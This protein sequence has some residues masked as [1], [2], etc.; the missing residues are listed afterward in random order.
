MLR[1]FL[2][3]DFHGSDVVFRKFVNALD[4]YKCDI[5]FFAGD[6]TG[7]AMILVKD[8]GNSK[9]ETEFLGD[10]VFLRSKE[11]LDSF[12]NKV[13]SSGFYYKII[14]NNE[15]IEDKNLEL[16]MR[17][18]M[19]KR[20]ETW[21]QIIHNK[22]KGSNKKFYFIT[23]ND[24]PSEIK[25]VIKSY[26]DDN[27]VDAN[28]KTF[29]LPNGMEGFGLPYSNITPWKLPG[30]LTEDALKDKIEFLT[31]KLKDPGNSVFLIHV[32]PKDTVIDLAPVLEN[33]S[34]KIDMSGVQMAHVGSTAVRDAIL[35][36][37]PVASLHGHIHESRGVAKIGRTYA[38]NAGSEYQQGILRGVILNFDERPYKL[39]SYLFVYG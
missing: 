1:A 12:L 31:S 23:G 10:K 20:T 2:A 4:V 34:L 9:Y 17:E 39:K 25:D 37:Q 15:I 14:K 3:S 38:F 35:K 28:E 26:S 32:P 5:A 36:Y 7:K 19:I 30:D 33:M 24:D 6:I 13:S 27:I 8:L 16:E 11:E 29:E 22:Y 21:M 18:L